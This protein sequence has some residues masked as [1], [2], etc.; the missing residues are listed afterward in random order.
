MVVGD[1]IFNRLLGIY[2]SYFTSK[3]RE[4]EKKTP[5]RA[6]DVSIYP[7]DGLIAVNKNSRLLPF[8]LNVGTDFDIL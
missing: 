5:T 6:Q 7:W 4:R 2:N 3:E 1:G 8:C